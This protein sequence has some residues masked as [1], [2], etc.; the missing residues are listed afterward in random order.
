[1]NMAAILRLSGADCLLPGGNQVGDLGLTSIHCVRI[2]GP[3]TSGHND[4]GPGTPCH[5]DKG[6]GKAGHKIKVLVG[7]RS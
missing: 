6:L 2:K 7:H 3:G 5:N 1:M 4:K